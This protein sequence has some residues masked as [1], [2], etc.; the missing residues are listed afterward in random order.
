MD[1]DLPQEAKHLVL[2]HRL[3]RMSRERVINLAADA[4]GQLLLCQSN[5]RL[6]QVFRIRSELDARKKLLRKKKRAKEKQKDVPEES[7]RDVLE[8]MFVPHC[9]LR[10]PCKIRSMSISPVRDIGR[11]K[12]G[13]SISMLTSLTNNSLEVYAVPMP[14]S[15]KDAEAAADAVLEPSKTH[16]LDMAGH[17]GDIRAVMLS[18]VEDIACSAGAQELKVW[19]LQ[20]GHCLRTMDC[21]TAFCGIFCPVI[22]T[23]CSAQKK[24]ISRYL[25]SHLHRSSPVLLLT[26]APSGQ[27]L[28]VPIAEVSSPA[29][30]QRR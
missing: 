28:S 21:G 24:A 3:V 14:V 20:T 26:K 27:S 12:S 22:V 5:D 23:L 19:N 9:L 10:A 17:R 8:A 2:A 30:L 15:K 11:A 7:M 18:S 13:K 4:S 1:I 29:Q 16:S 6:V 25:T